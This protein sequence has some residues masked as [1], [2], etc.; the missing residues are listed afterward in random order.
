MRS[1][2]KE[3][4]VAVAWLELGAET[5]EAL[6]NAE[7]GRMARGVSEATAWLEALQLWLWKRVG[8]GRPA[9][10]GSTLVLD[11]QNMWPEQ[12][13]FKRIFKL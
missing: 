12:G 3:F 4:E 13:L 2:P 9:A 1:G 6:W 10:Q 11:C 5:C 8:V 7:D